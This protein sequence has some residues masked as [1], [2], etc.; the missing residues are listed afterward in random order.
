[1]KSGIRVAAPP[2]K[3]LMVFDGDC[4]FCTLWV[5][6]WQQMTGDA[7]DYLPAQ[8]P[9][10]AAQFPEIPREQF[11]TAVQLIETD[12]SV[13]SGAEA[14][15]R[16]LAHNPKRQWPLPLL[17][18]ISAFC[19]PHRMGLPPGRRKPDVFLPA[20]ALVLGT[21]RRAAGLFSH[22]LDF[23]ARAGRDLSHRL[24]F[25][26]DA[27][28]RL[29][30]HNGI[31]PA[32]QFMAAAQTTMRRA[33]HRHWTAIICCRRCAGS[34]RPTV[35]CIS[36]A[37]RERCWPSCLIIGIAPA[38]CLALLWLLYLSLVT[39]GRDFLGFQWDN[40]L[41]EAGFLAIFFAPLQLLPRAFAGSAAVAARALAAA[42]AVVQAHVFVRLRETVERRPELAQSHRAHVSLPNPAAAD[43]DWLVCEPIAVVV[44]K[45]VLCRDVLH[46]TWRAVPDFRAAPIAVLRRRGH[47]VSPNLDSADR[48]LHFF[49][50]ADAGAVPVAA[51]R[52]CV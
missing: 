19:R 5:R 9:R 40:L 2:P 3:P 43:V 38:P 23:S 50:L 32:D 27:N 16:T 51:R 46:R 25:V 14:V 8:D 12:G 47:C 33:G 24:R 11:D 45:S 49:Q 10:I 48:Q 31:L 4:N 42:V 20:D 15:F 52:F 7:V 21:A 30:G 28:Q 22:A 1:M 44:S 29:I 18:K 6:R 34:M 35:F 13:Y 26:V 37:R 39:V 17:R 41:L 36:N